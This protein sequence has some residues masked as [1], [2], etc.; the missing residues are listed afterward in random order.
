MEMGKEA[1]I[2]IA[3]QNRDLTLFLPSEGLLIKI[4]EW[5]RENEPFFIR[6]VASAHESR[7]KEALSTSVM[8]IIDATDR[9]D[10]AMKV[11]ELS[12][13]ELGGSR[14][15]MYAEVA[16]DELEIMA[17]QHG[18]QWLLGPMSTW[19]WRESL[20]RLEQEKEAY[21]LGHGA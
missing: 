4:A 8:A 14:T 1:M 3:R 7:I 16:H 17:R 21:L 13:E 18:V 9:P 2:D 6:L 12:I 19:H 5:Q 15:A 10:A 20:L 11:L